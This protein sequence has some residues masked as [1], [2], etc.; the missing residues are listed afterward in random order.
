MLKELAEKIS[1]VSPLPEKINTQFIEEIL[2]RDGNERLA[3]IL[4]ERKE[5]QDKFE[6][7]QDSAELVKDRLP[8]WEQLNKLVTFGEG[9]DFVQMVK[10]VEAI[11]E[12]RLLL[13]NPDLVKPLL[14]QT[15]NLL[16]Q[17]LN[18]FKKAFNTDYDARMVELQKNNFFLKLSQE[19]KNQILRNNQLLSKPEISDYDSQGLL[20]SLNHIS[21]EAWQTKISALGSQFDTALSQAVILL[22]PKAKIYSMPRKTLSSQ[23]EID[24]FINELKASLVEVL[25]NA[26]S[27]ILK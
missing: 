20:N 21:L 10:E 15:T 9:D 8:L 24:I 5:L 13:Q 23:A 27:I 6:A 14:E 25:K 26:K 16:K 12:D 7:W 18:G 2:F 4:V 19:Q 17:T 3:A 11:Y 1:G 22:E